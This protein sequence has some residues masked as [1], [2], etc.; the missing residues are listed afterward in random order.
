MLSKE[1]LEEILLIVDS[2]LGAHELQGFM[3]T[4]KGQKIIASMTRMVNDRDFME[5]FAS[6]FRN[7]T[8]AFNATVGDPAS[9]NVLRIYLCRH[10]VFAGAL[11]I[12]TEALAKA[13]SERG[14]ETRIERVTI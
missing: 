8:T 10:K 7:K 5:R 11:E 1:E 6:D 14:L 13:R 3:N 4:P 9:R 2:Y 12:F